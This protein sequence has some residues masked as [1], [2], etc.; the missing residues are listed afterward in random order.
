MCGHLN[1]S[2][3]SCSSTTFSTFGLSYCKVY[4]QVRGYQV[5]TPDT[6]YDIDRNIDTYYVDDISITHGKSLHKHISTYA[7][8]LREDTKH[9]SGNSH[10]FGKDVSLSFVDKNFTV[11]LVFS[12]VMVL[13]MFFASM[14]LYGMVRIVVVLKVPVVLITRCLGSTDYLTIQLKMILN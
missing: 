11:S 10:N 6:F 4:G 14:I 13:R 3:A 5:D 7:C 9:T 12:P 8:R 1:H 2:K